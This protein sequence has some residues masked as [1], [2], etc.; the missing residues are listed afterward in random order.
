MAFLKS[1]TQIYE[2][3]NSCSRVFV[4][5]NEIFFDLAIGIFKIMGKS[6]KFTFLMQQFRLNKRFWF[7]VFVASLLA[8]MMEA[9]FLSSI[10][11]LILQGSE[12]ESEASRQSVIQS[13]NS[14]ISQFTDQILPD[15]PTIALLLLVIIL[16]SIR[17]GA[18]VYKSHVFFKF[19]RAYILGF[20]FPTTIGQ[21]NLMTLKL[22]FRL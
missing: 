11:M 1:A 5:K 8:S 7:E 22:M 12:F 17:T 16:V 15:N 20:S 13:T 3:I 2:Q 10:R 19:V 9:M 21:R 4:E 14:S 6:L 18:M